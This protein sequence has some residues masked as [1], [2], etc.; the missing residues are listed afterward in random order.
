VLDAGESDTTLLA[1][2]DVDDPQAASWATT[3]RVRH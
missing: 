1:V 2:T 3:L